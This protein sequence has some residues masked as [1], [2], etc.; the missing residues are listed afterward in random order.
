MAHIFLLHVFLVYSIPIVQILYTVVCKYCK[1]LH[2]Y[3]YVYSNNNKGPI[4][5]DI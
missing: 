5:R 3:S 2:M 4:T 1:H